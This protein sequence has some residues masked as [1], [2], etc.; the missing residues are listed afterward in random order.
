MAASNTNTYGGKGIAEDFEDVIWNISPEETTFLSLCKRKKATQT[1][2]QWL[3]DSLD[4]AASN[5][6]I[7]G[8]DATYATLAAATNLGNYCQISRKTVQISG[9]YDVVKK[10][11]RK[12]EV[13]YQLMKAGKALKR[14]MNYALVRNQGGVAGSVATAR[15]SAGME[16]WIK[17]NRVIG[18]GSS[19]GTTPGFGTTVCTAPTD[20]TQVAF[21]ETDLKTALQYAW[22]DGGNPTVLLM[23]ATNKIKFDAFAGIATQTQNLTGVQ[24]AVITASAKIYVSSYGTHT[25]K[26]DRQMRDNAVLCI[27]PEYVSIASLRPIQKQEMAKTGDS[28]KWL[29]LTEYCLV[30]DNPDA[31]AKVQDVG[32]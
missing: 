4:S 23:S 20:G 1:Y 17:G 28:E 11:G 8:D 5:T 22:T 14:D 30:V 18:S 10:Y 24:Q 3:T 13:A 9:T 32:A 12:S 21:Q 19:S 29:L 15:T 27:D 7:E 6:Q 16:S 31:H 2:H 25:A 26:L